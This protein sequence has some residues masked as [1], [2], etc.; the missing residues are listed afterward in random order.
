M[1]EL[2][3]R[4]S[5]VSVKYARVFLRM[6]SDRTSVGLSASS[7]ISRPE[8]PEAPRT[9]A[10]KPVIAAPRELNNMQPPAAVVPA[11]THQ[12]G[13]RLIFPRAGD[14]PPDTLPDMPDAVKLRPAL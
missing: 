4:V 7:I 9:P 2:F 11:R 5:N 10:P 3:R 8:K 13:L 6:V 12:S 1:S 14:L